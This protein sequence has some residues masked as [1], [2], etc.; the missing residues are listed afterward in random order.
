VAQV[1]ERK[2][3]SHPKKREKKN[4]KWIKDINVS[5]KI[6]KLLEENIGINIHNLGLVNGYLDMTPNHKQIQNQVC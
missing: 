1:I 2:P 5:P 6:I 3:Q 4:S